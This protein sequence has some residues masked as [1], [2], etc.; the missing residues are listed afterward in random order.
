MHEDPDNFNTN[1]RFACDHMDQAPNLCKA[2]KSETVEHRNPSV[3]LDWIIFREKIP[4]HHPI[5][6][7]KSDERWEQIE[8]KFY[9]MTDVPRR[10]L[11]PEWKNKLLQRSLESE[12]AL[13]PERWHNGKEG[14]EH[15][16]SDFEEKTNSM[17][18][19]IDIDKVLTTSEWQD[20]LTELEEDEIEEAS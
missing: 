15:L 16:K 19:S 4:S 1:V 12:I 11:S 6:L 7:S 18:C 20:F 9:E 17:L 3:D 5:R 14:L 13:T 8:V 10:C 2:A